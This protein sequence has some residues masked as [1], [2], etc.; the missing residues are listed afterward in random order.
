[1][2]QP[3][4]VPRT[5]GTGLK[6]S[7]PGAGQS[8]RSTQ[9]IVLP[10]P[11]GARP[12]GTKALSMSDATG[13]INLPIGMILRCMP[14]ET[15]SGDVSDFEKTG[16]AGT[17]VGLPMNTIL[18][19]L[20][21]GKVEMTV[22]EIIPHLPPGYLQPAAALTHYQSTIVSLPLMDVVMRIPPD[23]LTLRPDQKDVDAAV[24]NMADPFTEEIL[25]E[26][27]EAAR[28]Q[29]GAN[30]IE[31]SQAPHEEFVP[32]Q[33]IKSVAP[34]R[35]PI[36][37]PL[38]PSRT[39]AT[40]L[41]AP[42]I[43][44]AK[45]MPPGLAPQRS[46][47]GPP[48]PPA[49]TDPALPPPTARTPTG[50]IPTPV[51]MTA[52]LPPR[53][54]ERPPAAAPA[55]VPP[56]PRHT[57]P[58]P[59]PP[60]PRH[61]TSLPTVSRRTGTLSSLSQSL[62]GAAR[63]A[64]AAAVASGAASFIVDKVEA[65]VETPSEVPAGEKPAAD[66]A[67]P[68]ITPGE[69][70][71]AQDDLQRLAALAMAQ[72]GEEASDEPAARP[73]T[74]EASASPAPAATISS[75]AEE[76]ESFIPPSPAAAAVPEPEPAPDSFIS[77]P[78]SEEATAAVEEPAPMP[79]PSAAVP[80][81]E[82]APQPIE[83]PASEPITHSEEPI[84]VPEP[85]ASAVAPAPP[86]P[87]PI[88]HSEEPIRAPAPEA[89]AVAPAPPEPAPITHSEEPIR[90]PAP[91]PVHEAEVPSAAVAFNLNTCTAD[92]LVR[93]I[94]DCS[95]ALAAA[96]IAHRETIGSF[97]HIEE[98]LT[99]P[100]MTREAYTNLTGEAP[101]EAKA[102]HTI[103]D[104]LGF[105]AHQNLSLK[106]ITERIACWPDVTG[107]LLSQSSGLSLVGE[108]PPGFDKAAV[109]AFAPRMFETLNK[110]YAEI[111]GEE[112]DILII[113]TAGTSFHLFRSKDLYL[114]IMSRLP[115]MPE[116]HVK[117][118]R[119]VVTALSNRKD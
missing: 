97:A 33:A 77:A 36:V 64:A 57:G 23:L 14:P 90:A 47:G 94:T 16:A 108:A 18:G 25:R 109:V 17:E 4:S 72:M 6:P 80:V 100:G 50:Q 20:P 116:R 15:L 46:F 71:A 1:M 83:A 119:F 101:P 56:V 39:A 68:V 51:R 54:A 111:T 7:K 95:P 70:D 34:P 19:Q 44:A 85:E 43:P 2:T 58:I 37:E 76:A 65:K 106:D 113:P 105:P 66:G 118:A 78:A 29:T 98:L 13:V 8:T 52:P 12:N 31:E 87:A 82:P 112:T 84:R 92:D 99:V 11:P 3:M 10:T 41:A 32:S 5:G 62:T 22:G 88:A 30:I 104:L 59:A 9:R 107:C 49:A 69:P 38:A 42:G 110:S 74:E 26:Q 114:I 89:P 75:S 61:T 27:A 73:P 48:L 67:A 86:E 96:I 102:Q 21:S 93:H 117:V 103:N 53:Q 79:A 60:P 63:A 24:I 55:P 28:R 45:P 35:R 40:T 91:E 81:E 115:L